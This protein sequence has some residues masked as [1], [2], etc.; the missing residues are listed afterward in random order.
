MKKNIGLFIASFLL[1][2][3]IL[4]ILLRIVYGNQPVFLY[5]QVMHVP[6]SYGYKLKPNQEGTFTLDKPVRSNSYG[7]RDYEWN[8][9]KKP[10]TYRIMCLGDSFTFGNAVR[11]EDTYPKVLERELRIGGK[12]FEV[13]STAIG[14][15]ATFH[16]LDFLKAEGLRYEPDM[17]IIGF[18]MNDFGARSDTSHNLTNDGRWDARPSWL[19]WLPY[20]YIFLIKRSALI[21]Y[22]RDRIAVLWEGGN[23]PGSLLLKNQID[24]DND[25]NI[26]ITYEYISEIKRLCDER[27]IKC[28]LASIPAINYFWFPR[29]SVKYMDHL[30][31]FCDSQGIEFIDL[32]EDFWKFKDTNKFYMYPWDNHLNPAGHKLV[33]D[34]LFARLRHSTGL[35]AS[36]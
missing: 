8:V 2:C 28:I 1:T 31:K 33:A 19:Q 32:A 35:Q 11:E 24:M 9:P 15:W 18:F 10:G 22:L 34:Q 7:F 14:G 13:I 16:E 25:G 6:T 3:I 17:I 20:K 30:K 26:K 21:S 12:R 27:G 4:E 36:Q 5:P 29:G 23:D